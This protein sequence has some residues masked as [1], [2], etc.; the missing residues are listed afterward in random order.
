MGLVVSGNYNKAGF[1]R[2]KWYRIE[3]SKVPGFN[4]IPTSGQNALMENCILHKPIPD[5]KNIDIKDINIRMAQSSELS[6]SYSF[7]EKENIFNYVTKRYGEER[8]RYALNIIDWYIDTAYP[9]RTGRIH[10]PENKAKRVSFAEKLLECADTTLLE[11]EKIASAF[12]RAIENHEK[13]DPTIYW[14]TTPHVLGY[15]LIK[16]ED[17]GYES[18]CDTKYAPVETIY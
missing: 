16:D 7:A 1:D 3:Y 5:T 2:T 8:V 12:T 13:C 14:M 15:W 17:I 6:L 10:P 11:D 18:I 4:D 9:V